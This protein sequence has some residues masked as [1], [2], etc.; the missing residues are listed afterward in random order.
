MIIGYLT[1]GQTNIEIPPY[2]IWGDFLRFV[3][4]L[5]KSANSTRKNTLYKC[6]VI[7]VVKVL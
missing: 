7:R 2:F 1:G 4:F 6:S 3:N 5:K